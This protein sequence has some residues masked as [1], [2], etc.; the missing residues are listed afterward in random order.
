MAPRVNTR[1]VQAIL[2]NALAASDWQPI[3]AGAISDNIGVTPR[4][5]RSWTQKQLGTSVVHYLNRERLHQARNMLTAYHCCD[6][7][8]TEVAT[9][10]GFFE[11]GRFSKYYR[12]QF[13]ELPSATLKRQPRDDCGCSCDTKFV[14]L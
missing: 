12:R 8:V 5:L 7:S 3:S 4:T 9:R 10:Y 6:I 11:L 1:R 2:D 14:K 13:G